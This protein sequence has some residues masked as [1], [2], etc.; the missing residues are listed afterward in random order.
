VNFIDIDKN[1]QFLTANAIFKMQLVNQESDWDNLIGKTESD[2][3]NRKKLHLGDI[4]I[5]RVI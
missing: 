4:N 3:I 5:R 1:R 2:K